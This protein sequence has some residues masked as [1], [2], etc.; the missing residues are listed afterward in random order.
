[1]SDR[2]QRHTVLE[3]LVAERTV[4]SQQEMLDALGASGF[5]VHQSTLSR[6]LAELGIRKRGGRYQVV[7]RLVP[8]PTSP[9]VDEV[10]GTMPMVHSFVPCGPN[11]ITVH[12]GTGQAQLLGVML[13]ALDDSPI[14]GTIAGDDTVLVVTRG[15]ADQRAAVGLLED[16]FAAEA[17]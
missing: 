11:L 16:W 17:G 1:M 14:T 3:R 6:D 8:R 9:D 5:E 13:D 10:G 7:E 15:R 4:R 12:T 2:S